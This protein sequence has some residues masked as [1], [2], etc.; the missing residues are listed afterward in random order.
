[1]VLEPWGT[2]GD[3]GACVC[4]SSYEK[5]I[6]WVDR[7]DHFGCKRHAKAVSCGN[8]TAIPSPSRG[9]PF[10]IDACVSPGDTERITAGR[11]CSSGDGLLPRCSSVTPGI[12]LFYPS[13]CQS[14]DV[15]DGAFIIDS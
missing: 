12:S 7:D 1:M 2:S 5:R 11:N 10:G 8:A 4:C 3:W 9:N 14:H 6:V 15:M 13:A